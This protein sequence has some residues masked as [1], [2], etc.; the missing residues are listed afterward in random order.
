MNIFVIIETSGEY[1]DYCE[2]PLFAVRTLDEATRIVN[3]LNNFVKW[4]KEKWWSALEASRQWEEENP[5]PT[6]DTKAMGRKI[7]INWLLKQDFQ[8]HLKAPLEE[9]LVAI[10]ERLQ[11]L[12]DWNTSRHAVYKAKLDE[13]PVPEKFS[14][15]AHDVRPDGNY[16]YSEVEIREP[17][18]TR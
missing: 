4:K 15:A 13:T 10:N 3:Q 5:K 14:N 8:E 9:E 2:T 16:V 17:D 1:D 6:I 18:F 12:A 11:E 7:Q